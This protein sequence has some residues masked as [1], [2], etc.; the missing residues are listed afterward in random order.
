ML[1]LAL[2]IT[3]SSYAFEILSAKLTPGV[4]NL[5]YYRERE[6]HGTDVLFFGSSAL[7]CNIEFSE[8]WKNFGIAGFCLGAGG[9]TF[10]D[11]YYR[12]VEACKIY[13]P[14]LVVVEIGSAYVDNE[15]WTTEFKTENITGLPMS[16]NKLNFVHAA[17]PLEERLDYFLTFPLYHNRYNRLTSRDF[18]SIN[19]DLGAH[20]KGH[21][22]RFY[23]SSTG[24]GLPNVSAVTMIRSL[25]QKQEFYLRKIISYCQERDLPL[26]LLKTPDPN[27]LSRQRFYNTV[28]LIAKESDVPYLDMNFYDK[29]IGI[30]A[31]DIYLD[32]YHLNVLGARKCAVFLGNY[33]QQ[34]YHLRDHRDVVGYGSWDSFA[35]E[36]ENS[37]LRA[38]TEN[39]DYFQELA[40]DGQRVVAIPHLLADSAS[41]ELQSVLDALGALPHETLESGSLNLDGATLS[42]AEASGSCAL[43]L[44][45]NSVAQ[46]STPG[47]I[48]AVW[49]QYNGELADVTIFSA[50]NAYA[51]RRL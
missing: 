38:I 32:N 17:V 49:D 19:P 50:D 30:T 44:N 20:N 23:G 46:I 12:L 14:R 26:L 39:G 8:L 18:S 4:L 42:V 13:V 25:N 36:I 16:I 21:W 27:R 5:K 35:Y 33:L 24:K 11:D 9:S 40:R 41:P 22:T 45:G 31:G 3:S 1:T 47:V 29:E 10:Y 2:F 15:Y 48:L 7:S 34:H 37:Y 51:L 6:N 43:L 28:G